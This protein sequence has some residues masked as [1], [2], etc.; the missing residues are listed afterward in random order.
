MRTSSMTKTYSFIAALLA[1]VV[2]CPQL[3]AQA[4][5]VDLRPEVDSAA[6]R[7][8]QVEAQVKAASDQSQLL[9]LQKELEK[10]R[11]QLRQLSTKQQSI[12]RI[13]PSPS[14]SQSTIDREVRARLAS[15][16]HRAS[17]ANEQLAARLIGVSGQK[18]L[19][20]ACAACCRQTTAHVTSQKDRYMEACV[21]G[22]LNPD[23]MNS[24]P[25]AKSCIGTR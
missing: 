2:F 6:R 9:I 7:V 16:E 19:A 5:V 1:L 11:E 15:A 21:N 18:N 23:A 20:T 17:R 24:F 14:P 4:P 22:C 12:E 8:Q 10:I 25:L 3:A 13:A